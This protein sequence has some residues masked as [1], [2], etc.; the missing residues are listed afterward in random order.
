ADVRP[1]A[2]P[3]DL[4]AR[5]GLYTDRGAAGCRV[6]TLARRALRS[7]STR[8][9]RVSAGGCG[10]REI[11]RVAHIA[12]SAGRSGGRRADDAGRLSRPRASELD[13]ELRPLRACRRAAGACER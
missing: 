12:G 2:A 13:P 9:D 11:A 8:G 7:T 3:G 1:R 10:L 5:G 4:A 6:P